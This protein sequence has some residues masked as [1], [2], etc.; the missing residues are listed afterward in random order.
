[1]RNHANFDGAVLRPVYFAAISFQSGVLRVN[2][3][4]RHITVDGEV[5]SAV[6]SLGQISEY[7]ATTGTAATAMR[8]TLT[9]LP[10][11][12]AQQIANENAINH[13]VVMRIGLMDAA[14][15]FITTPFIWFIGRVD[16]I[17]LNIGRTTSV[18]LSASSRLINWAKATNGRYTHEDQQSKY[19]ADKGMVFIS[20]LPQRKILWGGG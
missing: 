2:S 5:Y 4:D 19:P 8:L 18:S 14:H 7:A 1:M 20:Q 15:A 3:S 6:G 13:T 10:N 9:G 17:S 12:Q 11:A 16:S